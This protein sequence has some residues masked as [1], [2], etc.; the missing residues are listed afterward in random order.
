MKHLL[1]RMDFDDHQG[2]YGIYDDIDR[3]IEDF[4]KESPATQ[5]S[6]MVSY[7]VVEMDGKTVMD[8]IAVEDIV[9]SSSVELGEETVSIIEAHR[10]DSK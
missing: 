8:V 2:V 3:F 7:D 5:A 1:V 6:L 9:Y 10:G 4:S